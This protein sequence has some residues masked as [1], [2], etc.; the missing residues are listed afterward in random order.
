MISTDFVDCLRKEFTLEFRAIA[1]QE[2]TSPDMAWEAFF[3]FARF[4][5][6]LRYQ[7]RL[8]CFS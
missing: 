8:F 4:L 3:L 6:F 2:A 7:A 1:P 5:Y